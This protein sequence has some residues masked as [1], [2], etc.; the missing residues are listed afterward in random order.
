MPGIKSKLINAG[1]GI[2]VSGALAFSGMSMFFNVQKDRRTSL[3]E[4]VYELVLQKYHGDY[5]TNIDGKDIHVGAITYESHKPYLK[6]RGLYVEYK[7]MEN[8]FY[9]IDLA[10]AGSAENTFFGDLDGFHGKVKIPEQE[11]DNYLRIVKKE[12]GKS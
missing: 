3:R 10:E 4:R 6:N 9:L 7:D 1:L 8:G 12:I 11:F 5:Y 2:L